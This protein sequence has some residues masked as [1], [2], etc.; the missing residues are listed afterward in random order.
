MF[1]KE[2]EYEMQHN[3]V[4]ASNLGDRRW[5]DK[6]PDLSLEAMHE[7]FQHAHAVLERLHVID[8]SQLSSEDQLNYDVFD[9]NT[10]D[11]LASEPYKWYLIRTNTF[12]GIQTVEGLVNSLRFETVKDYDDWLGRHRSD[13]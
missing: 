2:W 13:A 7:K 4:R 6:W 8:R 10:S 11:F 5:N 9:Y 12:N 1:D 3:P